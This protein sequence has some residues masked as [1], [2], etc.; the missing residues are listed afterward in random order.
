MAADLSTGL[1][2]NITAVDRARAAVAAL[3]AAVD[4][5]EASGLLS[6]FNTA[7]KAARKVQATI[8]YHDYLYSRKAAVLEAIAPMPNGSSEE[9]LR[10]AVT[11][12]IAQR[13][14]LQPAFSISLT[15][16]V[17]MAIW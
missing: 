7:F 12:V 6:E 3:N 10:A 13:L 11:I 16:S 14:Q 4:R 17:T 8:R 1:T 9:D 15:D 5:M 2:K